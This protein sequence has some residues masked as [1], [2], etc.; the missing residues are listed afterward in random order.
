VSDLGGQWVANEGTRG[1][2]EGQW[3]AKAGSRGGLEGLW[4]D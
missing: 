3:V 2:L 1:G 4:F